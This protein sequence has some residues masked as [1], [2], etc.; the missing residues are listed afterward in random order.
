M[1]HPT[2]DLFKSNLNEFLSDFDGFQRIYTDGSKAVVETAM[3][4][5][6]LLVKHLPKNSSIFSAEAQRIL[7]ALSIIQFSAH[8]EF[9]IPSE[10]KE[11][12]T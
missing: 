2:P 3:S 6:T 11:S 12:K 7:L 9:L 4:G 5:P 8:D 10:Y 1:G